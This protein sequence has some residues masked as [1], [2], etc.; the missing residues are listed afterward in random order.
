MHKLLILML[1]LS[2]CSSM[3]I[4]QTVDVYESREGRQCENTGITPQLSAEKLQRAGLIVSNS[5]CALRT[6]L[7]F[8][9]QCGQPNGEII[10]HTLPTSGLFK[11][12]SI[13]FARLSDLAQSAGERGYESIICSP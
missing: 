3:F 4:I 1:L 2:G 9:S 6:D 13:G 12:Q 7:S 10:V 8:A 11:A 5:H